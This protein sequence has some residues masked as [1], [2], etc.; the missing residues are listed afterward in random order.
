MTLPAPSDL[1]VATFLVLHTTVTSAS[2]F[3]A[4]WTAAAD[5]SRCAVD[6]DP[7]PLP[8]I[9]RSQAPQGQDRPVADRRSLLEGRA[10]RLVRQRGA[11]PHADEPRVGA[12]L[13]RVDAEDLVP[14]LELG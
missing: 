9:C 7:L 3:L 5:G 13:P 11:F 14:G 8:G 6:E 2:K 4:S 1:T 12:E 10:G